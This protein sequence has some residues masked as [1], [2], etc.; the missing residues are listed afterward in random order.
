VGFLDDRGSNVWCGDIRGGVFYR[1][2]GWWGVREGA[3]CLVGWVK[4]GCVNVWLL[5]WV[6][7]LVMG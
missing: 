6:L 3:G 1:L 5:C 7:V 4:C 2:E